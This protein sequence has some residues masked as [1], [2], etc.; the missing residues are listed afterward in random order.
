[1]QKVSEFLIQED[2]L[3]ILHAISKNGQESQLPSNIKFVDQIKKSI[4]NS[5]N[6]KLSSFSFTFNQNQQ[7]PISATI[8]IIIKEG[9]IIGAYDDDSGITCNTIYLC[10]NPTEKEIE[11]V[12]AS[13]RNKHN[14]IILKNVEI[15]GIYIN[16]K[17]SD[18]SWIE[19]NNA[20]CELNLP[21]YFLND[22]GLLLTQW[23]KNKYNSTISKFLKIKDVVL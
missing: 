18:Y 4:E 21:V 10:N 12:I 13:G 7:L 17:H 3:I 11:K 6:C 23:N 14:E 20:S 16:V 1:M 15:F 5:K 8:G 19:I 22:C 2:E 9:D